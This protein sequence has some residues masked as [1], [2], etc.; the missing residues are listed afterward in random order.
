[1]TDDDEVKR[2]YDELVAACWAIFKNEQAAA[3]RISIMLEVYPELT[4]KKLR[5]QPD[6]FGPLKTDNEFLLLDDKSLFASTALAIKDRA[7]D[8]HS[9]LENQIQE[10]DRDSDVEDDRSRRRRRRERDR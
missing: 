3:A 9:A 4:M 8:Y 1:M 5:E 10:S 7:K 6:F 2:R